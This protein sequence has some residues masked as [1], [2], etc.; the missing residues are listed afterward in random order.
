MKSEIRP[1][2]SCDHRSQF[3]KRFHSNVRGRWN[4]T[5]V[6]LT[7]LR[8]L[9]FRPE[10]PVAPSLLEEDFFLKLLAPITSESTSDS[11]P[12]G[13]DRTPDARA[14]IN[15]FM[16]IAS[17]GL[18]NLAGFESKLGLFPADERGPLPE[19]SGKTGP[20]RLSQ[21]PDPSDGDVPCSFASTRILRG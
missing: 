10:Q 17:T 7:P 20:R 15:E 16:L 6:T 4:V 9:E 18:E 2:S 13:T 5:E 21:K 8:F 12:S 11:R 19:A 3:D 14:E 1:Q